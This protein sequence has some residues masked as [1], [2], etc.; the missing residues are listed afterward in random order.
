M[1]YQGFVT[2]QVSGL[3]ED[4]EE[5]RYYKFIYPMVLKNECDEDQVVDYFLIS[6]V[7]VSSFREELGPQE[8]G[9]LEEGFFETMVFPCN[10]HGIVPDGDYTGLY[11][12]HTP[13]KPTE[14]AVVAAFLD[15][16]K[17]T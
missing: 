2:Q 13:D 1:K 11:K 5:R 4:E 7:D 9:P 16:H 8:L 10:A 15:H 17:L 3:M 12:T 14:T 6:S